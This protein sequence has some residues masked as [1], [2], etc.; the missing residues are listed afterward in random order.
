MLVPVCVCMCTCAC[1]CACVHVP[2]CVYVYVC[3][4]LCVCVHVSVCMC[5]RV[6]V[7]VCVC[8]L[9]LEP[10]ALHKLSKHSV[11]ALHPNPQDPLAEEGTAQRVA[12]FSPRFSARR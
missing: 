12:A 2:L 7:C 6:C 11:T 1:V 4:Y 10:R 5:A 3:L 9:G 8:M